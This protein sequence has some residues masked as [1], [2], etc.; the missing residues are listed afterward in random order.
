[1]HLARFKHRGLSFTLSFVN[2]RRLQLLVDVKSLQDI[3]IND[4]V[5]QDIP[6]NDGVPQRSIL[7]RTL[8]V[9]NLN[10]LTG[11]VICNIAIYTGDA[12]P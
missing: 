10:D 6:I 7:G 4:G 9:L 5:L 2:S 12:T 8:S 3:P 11:F 1:M